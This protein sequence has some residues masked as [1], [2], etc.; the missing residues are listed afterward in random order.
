[1]FSP[2]LSAAS[3]LLNFRKFDGTQTRRKT[4]PSKQPGARPDA[5]PRRS[6]MDRI[7][8][9]TVS[10]ARA[11]GPFARSSGYRRHTR[12]T[13]MDPGPR[14]DRSDT[15]PSGAPARHITERAP[16][17]FQRMGA[18]PPP[19][20]RGSRTSRSAS[21]SMLKPKTASEMATAGQSAIHGA[22]YMNVRPEPESIAPHDG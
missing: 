8:R 6:R 15:E 22:W 16:S 13:A 20:K 1:M 5:E 3:T 17:K 4:V 10:A 19:R 2:R 11:I 9:L 18:R 7:S 21:P 12:R 14:C